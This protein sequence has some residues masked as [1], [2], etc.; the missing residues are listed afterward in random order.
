MTRPLLVLIS[1]PPGCGKTTLAAALSDRLNVPLV[2]LDQVKASLGLLA[3]ADDAGLGGF[4]GQRA[5]AAA[6]AVLNTYL[7]HGVSVIAEKAWRRGRSEPELLPLL[8]L[9]RGV[10]VHVSATQE[11]AVARGLARPA[12][13]GLVDMAEVQ[14]ALLAGDLVW[15]DFDPLALDVPLLQVRTDDGPVDLGAVERDLAGMVTFGGA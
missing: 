2:S 3:S 11:L 10:Q 12:R 6:Y 5:F 8:A 7:E 9:S 13:P 15:S 1:G 4:T 14:K